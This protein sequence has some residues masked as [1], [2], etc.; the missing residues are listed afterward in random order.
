MLDNVHVLVHGF[1]V[2]VCK[3]EEVLLFAAT[4]GAECF[5]YN[6]ANDKP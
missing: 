4:P 6:Q 5:L 2:C 3:E 1:D